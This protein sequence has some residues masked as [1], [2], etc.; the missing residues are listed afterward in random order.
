METTD[1]DYFMTSKDTSVLQNLSKMGD[2][3]RELK[4]KMLQLQAEA[5]MAEKEYEHYANNILPSAMHAA[6]VESLALANG[7]KMEVK[8]SYY[9]SPNKNAEDQ[10][11]LADWLQS[12]GGDA[13]IKTQVTTSKDSIAALEAAK[14]PYSKSNE[15][16]TSSLKA[17][18]KDKL[19][20]TSGVA[21]ISMEDIPKCLHFQEVTTIELTKEE[22]TK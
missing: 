1:Y 12:L 4:E 5:D 22:V 21:Q 11:I 20:L 18:I 7:G 3:L 13:L 10:K 9:C 8:R 14:I 2:H 19:G 6:G 17:F 15:V 16:N